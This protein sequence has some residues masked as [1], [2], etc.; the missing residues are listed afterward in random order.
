VSDRLVA[1]SPD[2]QSTVRTCIDGA[3][4]QLNRS[5]ANSHFP[6]PTI[7]REPDG[8]QEVAMRDL[9]VSAYLFKFASLIC[10]WARHD[11]HSLRCN[12]TNRNCHLLTTTESA[13]FYLF[14]NVA[15]LERNSKNVKRKANVALQD[16]ESSSILTAK[17][18]SSSPRPTIGHFAQMRLGMEIGC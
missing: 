5:P 4:D 6:Q 10:S 18:T 14:R 15:P 1:A 11:E 9:A 8:E 13:Y 2:R 17:T 7:T 3:A 12:F 16:H